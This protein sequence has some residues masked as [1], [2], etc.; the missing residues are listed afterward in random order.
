MSGG[1]DQ[2]WGKKGACLGKFLFALCLFFIL[3]IWMYNNGAGDYTG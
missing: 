2:N 3:L 1:N